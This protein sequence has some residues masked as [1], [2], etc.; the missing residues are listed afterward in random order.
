M[1]DTTAKYRNPTA[2]AGLAFQGGAAWLALARLALLRSSRTLLQRKSAHHG[3]SVLG[4][5][6]TQ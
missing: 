3:D 5:C 6:Q 2:Q 4:R 1:L